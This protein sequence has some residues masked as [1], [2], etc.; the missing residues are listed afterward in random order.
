VSNAHHSSTA[1]RILWIHCKPRNQSQRR[2]KPTCAAAAPA[3]LL[4]HISTH[5]PKRHCVSRVPACGRRWRSGP[6]PPHYPPVLQH[7]HIR[8]V[9]IWKSRTRPASSIHAV[10]PRIP[11]S[12]QQTTTTAIHTYLLSYFVVAVIP[13]PRLRVPHPTQSVGWKEIVTVGTAGHPL[14][15]PRPGSERPKEA[16]PAKGATGACARTASTDFPRICPPFHAPV[17][18][19]MGP[20]GFLHSRHA[21]GVEC[22]QSIPRPH[23]K[24]SRTC[25]A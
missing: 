23:S 7:S 4:A 9:R 19:K 22:G 14:V 10:S 3:A 2:G 20:F 6:L 1:H 17:A 13:S 5:P 24:G 11:T 18:R 8:T 25:P 16:N 21:S 12:P 15:A